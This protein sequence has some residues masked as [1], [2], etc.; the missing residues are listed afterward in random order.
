[1]SN[2]I[3]ANVI[4][5]KL[6]QSLIMVTR[7]WEFSEHVVHLTPPSDYGQSTLFQSQT[8][9]YTFTRETRNGCCWCPR[10]CLAT[11]QLPSSHFT[12]VAIYNL[13]LGVEPRR[14]DQYFM[15]WSGTLFSMKEGAH[16]TY[17]RMM[18]NHKLILLHGNGMHG[19]LTCRWH[20]F[21][22]SPI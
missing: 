18:G 16:Y 14:A 12:L 15:N 2:S 22:V 10:P 7:C 17:M 21:R 3:P 6:C 4:D 9:S 5:R 1:M 20:T 8:G 19:H 13:W 11:K